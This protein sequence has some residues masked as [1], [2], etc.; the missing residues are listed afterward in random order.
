MRELD[1]QY[2]AGIQDRSA[3]THLIAALFDNRS[4]RLERVPQPRPILTAANHEWALDF[5]SDLGS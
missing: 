2:K 5:A 4:K 1:Q 3:R